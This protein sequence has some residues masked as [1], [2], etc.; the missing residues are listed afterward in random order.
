MVDRFIH[1]QTL[2]LVDI[3]CAVCGDVQTARIFEVRLLPELGLPR[4]RYLYVPR[5]MWQLLGQSD[6]PREM[7]FRCHECLKPPMK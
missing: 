2:S 4:T 7:Y 1:G 3:H 6:D 5:P